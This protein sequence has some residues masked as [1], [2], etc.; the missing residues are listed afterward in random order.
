MFS[1][2]SE[3]STSLA[4]AQRF[5]DA[6]RL[7][8][9]AGEHGEHAADRGAHHRLE[10]VCAQ[11]VERRGERVDLSAGKPER[12]RAL[13]RSFAEGMERARREAKRY[14]RGG[15]ATL[16]DEEKESLRALGYLGP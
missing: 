12:Q 4:T 5:G 14:R 13:E 15:K 10:C 11:A 3:S 8:L 1:N 2:L 16:T 9:F 7:A 6:D